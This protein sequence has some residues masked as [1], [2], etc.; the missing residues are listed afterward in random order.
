L[1]SKKNMTC[2]SKENNEINHSEFQKFAIFT[3]TDFHE[4]IPLKFSF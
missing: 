4:P 2:K 3:L 1:K